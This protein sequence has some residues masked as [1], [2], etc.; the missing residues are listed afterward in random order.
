MTG[1][2]LKPLV[3]ALRDVVIG[4]QAM[5]ADEIPLQMLAPGSKKTHRSYVWRTPPASSAKQPMSFMTSAPA[6]PVSMFV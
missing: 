6:A 3:D 2:Q 4:Q 1:V 5:H